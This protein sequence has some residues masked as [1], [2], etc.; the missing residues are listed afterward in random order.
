MTAMTVTANNSLPL[1]S[2]PSAAKLTR[3]WTN[4]WTNT[5]SRFYLH[6][7]HMTNIRTSTKLF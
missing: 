3:D 6:H 7:Q 4:G 1:T 5:T 2:V